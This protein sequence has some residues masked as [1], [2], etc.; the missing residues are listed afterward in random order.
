MDVLADV[1][2]SLR[3][4]TEVYGR[5]ELSA[6]WGIRLALSPPGYFHFVS[7]GSCWLEIDGE[8][9]ALSTGDWIFVLG[10][11]HTL[12]D[13]TKSRARPLPEIYAETG[14]ACGG[15]LRHGGG[16]VT[17]TL[18]SFSFAI[19][20]HWLHPLLA[21]LPHVLHVRG[22]GA[23]GSRAVDSL[24][25]LV[26][27]E[28]EAGRA[29]H[30]VVATRI[31]DVLL[32]HA[33]RTHGER[34]ADDGGWLRALEDPRIGVVLQRVH[35]RPAHAWT[36]ATMAKLASMSRSSFAARF[37]SLTGES[38]LAYL[39]RW[40]IHRAMQAIRESDRALSA[41]AEFVGYRDASAFG[42]AFKRESGLS[43]AAYR[44]SAKGERARD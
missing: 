41:I 20:G 15:V 34:L 5:L 18:I 32:I 17:T 1:L 26:A 14:A 29:G 19:D 31:A 27:A 37:S 35:E 43:P 3:V 6:P 30:K 24:V 38:P 16:G 13:A 42:K 39:T 33:L 11:P 21:R 40:R 8:R 12:R 23:H 36:V 25:R 9:I 4:K 2:M 22:D 28:M 44:R 10:G 7:R